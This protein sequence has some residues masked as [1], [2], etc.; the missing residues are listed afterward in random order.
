MFFDI[1]FKFENLPIYLEYSSAVN[2]SKKY[3]K[4]LIGDEDVFENIP[5]S[6]GTSLRNRMFMSSSGT[7]KQ[8]YSTK[9]P[10]LP[11]KEFFSKSGSLITKKRN[12]LHDST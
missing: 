7:G 3:P 10:V 11:Q 1:R 6:I 12:L 4:K 2:R 8:K 5:E 9:L